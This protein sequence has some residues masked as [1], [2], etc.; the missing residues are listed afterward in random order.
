MDFSGYLANP[1]TVASVGDDDTYA[2][3]DQNN[4][5]RL[6]RNND[7]Q[8][9]KAQKKVIKVFV[10]EIDRLPTP[11]ELAR[12]GTAFLVEPW[13]EILSTCK[14]LSY[15]REVLRYNGKFDDKDPVASDAILGLF[16]DHA[17]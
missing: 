5:Y 7:G 17:R 10:D 6:P 13:V 1:V 12:F 11:E 14:N 9:T 2:Y 16:Y 15:L 8:L 4:K 3:L